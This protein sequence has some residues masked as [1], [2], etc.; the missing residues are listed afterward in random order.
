MGKKLLLFKFHINRLIAIFFIEIMNSYI[1][2]GKWKGILLYHLIDGKK[3]FNEFRRLYPKITQRMLTLQL[4]ELERDGVIHREVYKQVPPKVE[5]SLTEF[6]RTLEPVI[7]HM[8]D[9]GE[10]YRDRINKIETTR[11]AEEEI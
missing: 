7:L 6:G 9:W 1:H 11:K 10:K 2:G 8:K 5:Y 4:R 3:R